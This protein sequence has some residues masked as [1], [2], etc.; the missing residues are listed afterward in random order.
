MVDHFCRVCRYTTVPTNA[1]IGYDERQCPICKSTFIVRAIQKQVN[2]HKISPLI[3]SL[4]NEVQNSKANLKDRKLDKKI[5]DKILKGISEKNQDSIRRL[6]RDANLPKEVQKDI[7]S[8][9]NS[10]VDLDRLENGEKKYDFT[11]DYTPSRKEAIKL[12]NNLEQ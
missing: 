11:G 12:L 5:L 10:I 1:T 7:D 4:E 6:K 9:I 2:K 8:L 3:Q